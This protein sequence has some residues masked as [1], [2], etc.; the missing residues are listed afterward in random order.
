MILYP[1]VYLD[2]V[3]EITP[4]LLEENNISGII[5]DVDN[6][7]MDKKKNMPKGVKEWLD[8]LKEKGYKI[9]IV[10]NTSK[11]EKVKSTANY[12]DLPYF[13][14]SLKP[15]K[16][17][18]KKAKKLLEIEDSNRIAVVGDQVFTDV[19]GANRAKMFSILVKPISSEDIWV[20]VLN[21]KLEKHVL[22]RYMKKQ[23]KNKI[24]KKEN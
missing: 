10:S 20:T 22:K 7:L 13:Y 11:V 18:L 16:R 9:C 2:S 6:T 1:K 14:L 19:L 24:T 23:K 3:L 15:L 17:N 12:L 4:E 5:L 21:R 8:N